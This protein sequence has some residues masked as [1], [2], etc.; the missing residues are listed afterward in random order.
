MDTC[1]I[2]T[3][4]NAELSEAI[5][6]I[7]RWYHSATRCNVYLT[8]VPFGPFP[9][10]QFVRSRWFSR[11]WTLQEL[12]APKSMDFF[13]STGEQLGGGKSLERLIY[14]VTRI[15]IKALNGSEALAISV[16]RNDYLGRNGVRQK[17]KRAR[18]L[19]C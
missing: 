18:R 17:E 16:S 12:L 15:P 4:S 14:N 7:F 8:D 10:S 3:S 13:T 5:N 2:D 11:G 6:S 19:L 1:N 9:Y